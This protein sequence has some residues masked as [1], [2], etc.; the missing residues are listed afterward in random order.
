MLE[1]K[2]HRTVQQRS[3]IS[4][5]AEMGMRVNVTVVLSTSVTLKCRQTLEM[6]MAWVSES[7][8]V[9][10]GGCGRRPCSRVAY[11]ECLVWQAPVI[12]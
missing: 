7:G 1:R 6:G 9:S 2:S 5:T 4:E 12:P 8:R 10:E 3:M 11:R